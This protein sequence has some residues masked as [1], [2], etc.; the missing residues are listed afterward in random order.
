MTVGAALGLLA[1]VGAAWLA[2]FVILWTAFDTARRIARR[3][4]KP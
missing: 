3:H 1:F 2:L 4:R